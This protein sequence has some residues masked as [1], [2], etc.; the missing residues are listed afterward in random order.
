MFLEFFAFGE[1]TIFRDISVFIFGFRI[2]FKKKIT[3][4]VPTLLKMYGAYGLSI[5]LST[6]INHIQ[7]EMMGLDHRFSYWSTLGITGIVNYHT[8]NSIFN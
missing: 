8:V 3:N 6:I 1:I 7:V 2:V 4:Y 5:V